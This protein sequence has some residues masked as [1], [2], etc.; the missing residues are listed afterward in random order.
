LDLLSI[1]IIKIVVSSS[2]VQPAS[3]S[4][5]IS[6][7]ALNRE[8]SLLLL[9]L[10]LVLVLEPST[11]ASSLL[12]LIRVSSIVKSLLDSLALISQFLLYTAALASLLTAEASNKAISAASLESSTTYFMKGNLDYALIV[13]YNHRKRD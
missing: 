7:A 9:L 8:T 13:Q 12:L 2:L 6:N 10:S 3:V 1:V 4:I 11:I 5:I